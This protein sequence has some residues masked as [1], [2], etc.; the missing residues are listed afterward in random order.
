MP[1]CTRTFRPGQ[2]MPVASMPAYPC[3]FHCLVL[4]TRLS[5]PSAS[6]A[7]PPAFKHELEPVKG[8]VIF[9]KKGMA[10]D[11]F[12]NG[13]LA[14]TFRGELKAAR[15]RE[16]SL[17]TAGWSEWSGTYPCLKCIPL[18]GTGV[19]SRQHSQL[20]GCLSSFHASEENQGIWFGDVI[21]I[22]RCC[23]SLAATGSLVEI[24]AKIIKLKRITESIQSQIPSL[25]RGIQT[26][27]R[28][29]LSKSLLQLTK[30]DIF[31]V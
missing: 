2:A 15:R 12:S 14:P 27:R 11:W 30:M 9:W 23:Y 13:L 7:Q 4:P 29:C 31:L 19:C 3:L 21:L 20:H 5:V 6:S 28:A 8:A 10:T 17:H 16:I 24:R 18:T 1:G 25:A 22:W 26:V